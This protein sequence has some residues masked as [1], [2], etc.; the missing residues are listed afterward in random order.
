MKL[1]KDTYSPKRYETLHFAVAQ[2][3]TGMHRQLWDLMVDAGLNRKQ[4]FSKY[5]KMLRETSQVN[6]YILKSVGVRNFSFQM[7]K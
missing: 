3:G 2:H 4:I 1:P 6:H 5:M 7:D